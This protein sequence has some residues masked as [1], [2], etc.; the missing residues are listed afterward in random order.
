[1]DLTDELPASYPSQQTC[2]RYYRAW[3]ESGSLNRIMGA[4]VKDLAE[5]GRFDIKSALQQ[6]DVHI[7]MDVGRPKVEIAPH[8]QNTWQASTATV[9]IRLLLIR[10]AQLSK[11]RKSNSI[12]V[13]EVPNAGA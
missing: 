5:R 4:L 10:A 2:R 6:G 1:M 8:L 9:F 12:S 11:R 7:F 3:H 13:Q